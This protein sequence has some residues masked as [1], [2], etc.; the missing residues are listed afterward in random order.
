[1]TLGAFLT[2]ADLHQAMRFASRTVASGQSAAQKY[3]ALITASA[4]S[5]ARFRRYR[6]EQ[7]A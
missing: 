6:A 7:A 2:A 1:M 4:W 3:D 5:G